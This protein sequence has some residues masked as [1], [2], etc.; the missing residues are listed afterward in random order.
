MNVLRFLRGYFPILVVVGTF[1]WSAIVIASYRAREN[2]PRTVTLR[3]AH[4][5][6]EPGVRKAFDILAE[7]YRKLH[8]NVRIVQDAIPETTY[9]QWVSTQLMGG[10]APDIL[11]LGLGLPPNIWVAYMGRYFLPMTRVAEQPNPYNAGTEFAGVP[12][13]LTYKDGMRESYVEE[14]QDYMKIPLSQFGVRI[15]YNA[16][17]F[18]RLTGM[19]EPP[20]DYREF[21]KAC[22]IIKG[23]VNDRGQPYIPLVGSKYHFALWD[24]MMFEPMT[25][26]GLAKIDFGRDGVPDKDETFVAFKTERV[27]LDFPAFRARLKMVEQLRPYFQEGYTGLTRDEGVF[28]FAQ[29]RAV[30]IT[31]GTWDAG[32]LIEQAKGKF[33]VEIMGFP[34]PSADDPDFGQFMIGPR[35]ERPLSA[36]PFGVTRTSEHQAEAIDFLLFL[37]GKKQNEKLNSI[38]GW[39]PAIKDTEIEP[40]LAAFVPNLRGIYKGLDLNVGGE[41]WVRWQQ[42]YSL[43]QVGQVSL[44]EFIA[45]FDTF[46][47]ERG[48]VDFLERRNSWRRDAHRYEQL[49]A[50]IRA[51]AL[52]ADPAES[53]AAWMRYRVAITSRQIGYEIGKNK[54]LHLLDEGPAPD[55]IGPYEYTPEALAA[56]RARVTGQP[57]KEE[58]P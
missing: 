14:L 8:P 24:E 48:E 16:D 9:G 32:S 41:S 19:D 18:K 2:P 35:Y 1:A 58:K 51:T 29:E 33:D 3:I 27:G 11:E 28:L 57:A 34:M 7:D 53:E 20:L 37:A 26:V 5:Q 40:F 21:L 54:L 25:F 46:V 42:L 39:L 31:T 17:L 22:D 38:I 6:L 30:F 12:L 52:L 44:D 47:R 56:V 4:W 10:T 43:Y 13:R 50:G 55:A 15:F 45:E 49:T 36:F 23:Q